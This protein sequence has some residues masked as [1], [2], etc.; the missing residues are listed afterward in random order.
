MNYQLWNKIL[1]YNFDNPPSEYD[2]STRLAKQN[3]WTKDFTL[4][5]IREYKKFM[6]LAATS[7]NMVSPSEIVDVVWHQHLI[8]TQSYQDFCTVIGKQV[9]HV[10]STHSR[11]QFTQ[12][13][14][15]KDT[16]KQLYT[17]TFGEQPKSIWEYGSMYDSLKLEKSKY[18]LR[19]FLVMGLSI[20]IILIPV[21]YF[22]LRPIYANVDSPVFLTGFIGLS[23]LTLFILSAYDRTK[24][25]QIINSFDK[26][27]FIFN[28]HPNE[29]IYLQTQNLTMVVNGILNDLF[30]NQSIKL[31]DQK[32]EAV[33]IGSLKSKEHL[34]AFATLKEIGPSPH[35]IL[36]WKIEAKPV[37]KNIANCMD[38]FKKYFIKSKKFNNLFYIN[39]TALSLVFMFGVV[40]SRVSCAKNL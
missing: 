8:F 24:L 34:H 36:R 10:P 13:K 4:D 30:V 7:D 23:I 28:L 2:F 1:A 37:L 6:Y 26:D 39:F 12:F 32:F 22:L 15:A 3:F 5:A 33:E 31:T 14:Q 18:K 9:Q 38:A 19:T 20:F 25:Q 40:R 27:S 17:A 21:F 16:T 29:L 11:V 35:Q